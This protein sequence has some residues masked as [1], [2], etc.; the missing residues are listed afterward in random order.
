MKHKIESEIT[1][2]NKQ[3]NTVDVESQYLMDF[4]IKTVIKH[5]K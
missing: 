4:I 1:N 5:F 3:K 2:V